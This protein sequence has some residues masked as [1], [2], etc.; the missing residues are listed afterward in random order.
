MKFVVMSLRMLKLMQRIFYY[1]KL[2][3]NVDGK[4][5]DVWY[6][7]EAGNLYLKEYIEEDEKEGIN[8]AIS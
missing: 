6:G 2:V 7:M 3:F 1:E 5:I 8:C 4:L